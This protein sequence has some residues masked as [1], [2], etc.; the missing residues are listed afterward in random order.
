MRRV[1]VEDAVGFVA[2][3]DNDTTNL[4]LIAGARRRNESLYVAARQNQP[5][6]APLFASMKLDLVL[7]PSEVIAHEVYAQLS[8]PLLWRF[9]QELPRLGEE[10]AIR[11]LQ[12]ITDRCGRR[13]QPLW[14]IRVTPVE[15]PALQAWLASG[16]ATLH[17]LFRD[18]DDRD[19]QLEIVPLLLLRDGEVMMGPELDVVLAPGDE[20]LLAGHGTARRR[21][22]TTMLLDAAASYVMSG[23]TLHASWIWRTLA[24]RR[25]RRRERRD[26]EPAA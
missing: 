9:L 7:V 5:A 11:M 1:G 17:D 22:E 12:R 18:P 3:T 10:S 15:A 20:L 13:L 2:G 8:T 25:S 16:R 23:E 6:N 14:K 21:L 26:R 24:D 19:R 4:S